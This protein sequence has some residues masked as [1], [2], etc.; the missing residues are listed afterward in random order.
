MQII[1]IAWFILVIVVICFAFLLY[2]V[3]PLLG[4]ICLLIAFRLCK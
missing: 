1:L 2:Q 4:F 3:H